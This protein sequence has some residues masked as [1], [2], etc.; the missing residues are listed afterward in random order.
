MQVFGVIRKLKYHTALKAL[1][2]LSIASFCSCSSSCIATSERLQ[3]GKET[4][5]VYKTNTWEYLA[6]SFKEWTLCL[7][8]SFFQTVIMARSTT[9]L[10]FERVKIKTHTPSENWLPVV[11]LKCLPCV[12]KEKDAESER[13]DKNSVC[14]MGPEPKPLKSSTEPWQ[15]QLNLGVVFQS[16]F[17][18]PA[19]LP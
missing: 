17:T 8:S 19:K 4:A 6:V 18:H 2:L 16:F 3:R 9:K 10:P 13:R 1:P 7:L 11:F 5:S 15:K 12:Q 14:E